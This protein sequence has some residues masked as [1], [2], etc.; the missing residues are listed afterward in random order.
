MSNPVELNTVLVGGGHCGLNL[1][2]WLAEKNDTSYIVLERGDLLHAWKHNR[3][4]AFV[5]NTPMKYSRLHNQNDN[6]PDTAMARPLKEDIG[7][8]EEHVKKMGVT[9]R[10]K[11]EVT[12]VTLRA[13]G[14]FVTD[15]MC[16]DGG[17]DQYVSSNVVACNGNYDHLSIP[18]CRKALHPSIR[19]LQS[20]RFRSEAQLRDGAVL[21]VGG[22][23]SG[24][25]LADVLLRKGKKVYLCTSLVPGSVRSYRGEDV[26]VWMERTGFSDMTKEA[27]THLPDQMAKALRYGRIPVT[28]STKPISPFSLHRLGATLLGGLEGV[29][30]DGMTVTLKPNRQMNIAV[31][32]EAYLGLPHNVEEWLKATGKEKEFKPP[33][34]FPEPEWEPVT[35][36]LEKPGPQTLNLKEEGITNVLWATGHKPDFSW[37]KIDKVHEGFDAV[38]NKPNNLETA[39]PGF[40]F[41]GFHWLN[42]LQSGNVLGFDKDH[43]IIINK[44]R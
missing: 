25:Q 26:F 19:Q 30:D 23:Q 37:I 6:V 8:W 10:E 27:L 34:D 15:V 1:G 9:C 39:V 7:R 36:L 3:W 38:N 14:R 43:E 5:M 20:D 44:L 24:V 22:G 42:T 2:C 12:S 33:D 31:C 28:G 40:F 29:G 21:I 16:A 41:A 4:D 32:A 18:E 13:D 17:V 35:E 11:C